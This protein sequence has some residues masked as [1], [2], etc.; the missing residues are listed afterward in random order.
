ML[1][2][3]AHISTQGRKAAAQRIAL[4]YCLIL[5]PFAKQ[6]VNRLDFT[7]KLFVSGIRFQETIFMQM[8]LFNPSVTAHMIINPG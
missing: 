7:Q 6:Q 2:D 3:T 4:C 1:V 5:P 8:V